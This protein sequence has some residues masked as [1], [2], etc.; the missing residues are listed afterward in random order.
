MPSRAFL[1]RAP[2]GDA[3]TPYDTDHAPEYLRLLDAEAAGADWQEVARIVLDVD[4]TG[5]PSR[6][7]VMYSTHLARAKWLRDGGYKRLI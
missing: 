5:D 7:Q 4:P 1:D 2:E 6:A 3:I